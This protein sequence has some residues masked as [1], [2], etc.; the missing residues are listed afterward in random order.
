MLDDRANIDT[1]NERSVGIRYRY[2]SYLKPNSIMSWYCKPFRKRHHRVA[3][4]LHFLHGARYP[5]RDKNRCRACRLGIRIKCTAVP[6]YSTTWFAKRSSDP[7][8]ALIY[9]RSHGWPSSFLNW[10]D[11]WSKRSRTPP[12]PVLLRWLARA[13]FDYIRVFMNMHD[14]R[15]AP[16]KKF[17]APTVWRFEDR[18]CVRASEHALNGA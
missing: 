4:V 18:D 10:V 5:S 17:T 9:I 15:W 3:L 2:R 1:F 8:A 7:W 16:A 11:G 14:E 12:S 6:R 13:A